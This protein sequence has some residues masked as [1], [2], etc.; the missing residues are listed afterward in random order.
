M[1][2]IPLKKNGSATL[3]AASGPLTVL[4]YSD[5]VTLTD[6][7]FDGKRLALRVSVN[8]GA[9]LVYLHPYV[10]SN[11]AGN[12]TTFSTGSGTSL[13]KKVSTSNSKA[14]TST[15]WLPLTIAHSGTTD[16]LYAVPN[17]KLA[18]R[19]TGTTTTFTANLIVG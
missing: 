14:G 12:Y 10:A 16:W 13:I 8:S 4:A 5:S 15:H 19:A 7:W 18:Y 2:I 1:F 6:K 11:P 17:F 3:S 9:S